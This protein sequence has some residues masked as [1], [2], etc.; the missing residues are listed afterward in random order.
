MVLYIDFMYNFFVRNNLKESKAYLLVWK[1]FCCTFVSFALF[2]LPLLLIYTS[3]KIEIYFTLFVIL[4]I[5]LFTELVLTTFLRSY[6]KGFSGFLTLFLILFTFLYYNSG[7]N[8]FLLYY[9]I[10]Y[11]I[12]VFLGVI[13][14]TFGDRDKTVS[15]AFWVLFYNII[16]LFFLGFIY[17][18]L[19]FSGF[20][21]IVH[22][23]LLSSFAVYMIG[24][25]LNL[26][27]VLLFSQ[28]LLEVTRK[29][30]EIS[31]FTFDEN[32]MNEKILSGRRELRHENRVIVFGDIRGFT[33][34]TEKSNVSKVL[35]VLKN[36]YIIVEKCIKIYGGFKPEFI[37]DEFVTFFSDE[38]QAIKFACE[39]VKETDRLFEEYGLA[40]GVGVHRGEVLEGLIGGHDSKKYTIIGKAVNFASRLQSVARK[41][42]ILVSEEIVK[43]SNSFEIAESKEVKLKGVNGV[44]K[45]YSVKKYF[46]ESKSEEFKDKVERCWQRGKNWLFKMISIKG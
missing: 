3:L 32:T 46:C 20:D 16:K 42:E 17:F 34:F 43:N 4:L 45:V 21:E 14:E 37:A 26:V 33:S 22:I 6:I 35:E 15:Y 40:I 24:L 38:D 28:E 31:S 8:T 13:V 41:R 25:L 23:Y 39:V 36:F 5:G 7:I 2:G 1:F 11:T 10:L 44:K 12:Y 9:L 27:Q 19:R 29:L 18:L 30:K